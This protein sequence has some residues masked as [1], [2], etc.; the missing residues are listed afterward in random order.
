MDNNTNFKKK[1]FNALKVYEE[2]RG[3]IIISG[4]KLCNVH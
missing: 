2:M 4:G 1:T 3:N